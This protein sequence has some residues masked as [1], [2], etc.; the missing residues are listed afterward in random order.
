MHANTLSPRSGTPDTLPRSLALGLAAA[1]LA[2]MLY[3]MVDA[4]A[5]G[6]KPGLLFWMLL[7]LICGLFAQ[8]RTFTIEQLATDIHR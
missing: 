8:N 3:G 5:L 7:G 6:A 2:H 1:L 4:V